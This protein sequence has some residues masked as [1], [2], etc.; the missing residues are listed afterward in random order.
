MLYSPSVLWSLKDVETDRLYDAGLTDMEFVGIFPPAATV[1][2][3]YAFLLRLCELIV[4][5][6]AAQ[7]QG[8]YCLSALTS[9]QF[10]LM[11][12]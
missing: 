1:A 4:L 8:Q 2:G 3:L 7:D 11:S 12:S 5:G 9:P 10:L 6:E